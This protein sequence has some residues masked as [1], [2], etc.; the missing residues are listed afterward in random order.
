MILLHRSLKR[1]EDYMRSMRRLFEVNCK[2]IDGVIETF[3]NK[4]GRDL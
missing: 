3:N 2:T 1:S 4:T